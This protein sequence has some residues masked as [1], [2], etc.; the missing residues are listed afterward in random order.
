[1]PAPAAQFD[2]L[3]RLAQA[4]L[5]HMDPDQAARLRADMVE[6]QLRRRGIRDEAVLTAM[7]ELPRERFVPPEAAPDAYRDEA[8]GID[9]GQTISQPYMVARMTEL[10][11]VRPGLR[12]LEVGTGSG[13]Q[14]AVLA[15][16]GCRVVSVER[17][18]ELAASATAVLAQLGLGSKVRVVVG[19]G[20]LG[21]PEQA[22]YGAILV[23]AAAPRIPRPLLDQ[24]LEG[25]RL[26]IP[27]GSRDFQE[28]TVAVRN[29]D[30]FD[31]RRCGGCI[32]VPLV[33][34]EGF[35]AGPAGDSWLGRL[36]GR[37]LA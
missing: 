14:A 4:Y 30:R 3:E 37:R 22:P 19:D 34:Q 31:E 24:L 5:R 7:A 10:L 23:T 36:F 9:A 12:V 27:V 33:G 25:G 20:S 15:T 16:L 29:G 11:E 21:W 2:M 1:M 17:H 18:A 32:F 6:F 28:L 8:L 26:V 13:Y 35:E